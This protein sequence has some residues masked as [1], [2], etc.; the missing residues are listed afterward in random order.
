MNG[1]RGPALESLPP[2]SRAVS[3]LRRRAGHAAPAQAEL[4]EETA[5]A[6][7]FNGISGAVMMATPSDLDDFALGFALTEGI[8][9]GRDE[10]Y[11]TE[12][13]AGDRGLTL[14]I[15]LAQAAFQR[16][17]VRRRVLAGRT[18]CGLCG[19]DSLEQAIRPL[20]A[21]FGRGR[22]IAAAAI[23]RAGQALTSQQPL[24]Q[25]TGATHA[26][27]WCAVDGSVVAVREDVGRH[28][29][30]DKL[31]GALARAG[32]DTENGFVLV[33]SRASTE[34]V[35]KSAVAGATTL[36]AVSAPTATAVRIAIDCGM[37]LVGFA[38]GDDFT[39]Y[40]HAAR[41]VP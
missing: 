39:V 8:V 1:D 10:I 41:I 27:A 32:T 24:Q 11:G 20:P 12:V 28:N 19:I 40:A 26:A 21:R 14:E 15:E 4:P 38:R 25:A 16:M 31:I 34:M 29:A 5:V 22:T 35:Q 2:P 6:L 9:E 17:K 30:L 37:T 33:T 23:A 13:R 3:A 36:V 7:E 18:G